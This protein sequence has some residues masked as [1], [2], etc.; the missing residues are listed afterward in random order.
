MSSSDH[1]PNH[2]RRAAAPAH[3]SANE[4]RVL[5]RPHERQAAHERQA[6]LDH[7]TVPPEHAALDSEAYNDW[8]EGRHRGPHARRRDQRAARA[9]RSAKAADT[10]S[11]HDGHGEEGE[12]RAPTKKSRH[13]RS[14]WERRRKAEKPA[15]KRFRTPF[16]K[17]ARRI[18]IALV[19]VGTGELV[20]AALTTPRLAV[21]K[22]EIIGAKVTP[23]DSIQPIAQQLMGQN[24]F[25]V[26]TQKAASTLSHLPSVRE[27]RVERVLSLPPMKLALR[28]TEREP[29][30]RVGAGGDWWIVDRDGVP[31]RRAGKGDENL[32]A[33]SSPALRPELIQLGKPLPEK[34]WEPFV[35]L[36]SALESDMKSGGEWK[37]R[38]TYLDKF[39]FASLR[40]TGGS[41]DELLIR[42]GG[43]QWP[44]KLQRARQA[45]DY[46]AAT[47]RRA[48]ALNL[49]SY[50]MPTWTPRGAVTAVDSSTVDQ[51]TEAATE[52]DGALPH[53]ATDTATLNPSTNTA[54]TDA[55]KANAAEVDAGMPERTG[56]GT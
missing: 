47:G 45:L 8:L 48:A 21:Q 13:L 53:S 41:N 11:P 28:I 4:G 1:T 35:V 9:A 20:L 10:H 44:Q 37:L 34:S 46:F 19:V 38:R 22:V 30:A 40:L 39:G 12:S 31:F 33:V 24:W 29:F 26:R 2:R 50:N 32:H 36:A 23:T 6:L 51:P 16:W 5:R 3:N 52:G 14:L 49:V 7:A 25:R 54:E 27:A 18:T 42:L 43:G 15:L 56:T 17:V 55:E